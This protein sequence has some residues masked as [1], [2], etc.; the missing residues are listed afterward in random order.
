[1]RKIKKYSRYVV[2]GICVLALGLLCEVGMLLWQGIKDDIVPSDVGIVLGSSITSAGEPSPRLRA[3]LDRAGELW[4]ARVFP[5]IIVS[6]GVEPEGRDEAAVMAR[7]LEQHWHVPP[8]AIL[9]DATGNT[10]HDTA[11]HS[12]TLMRQYGYHSALVIS[13]YFHIARSQD[14]LEWAGINEVHH[15]HAHYF[16]SRDFYSLAREM[17]A[18]PIYRWYHAGPCNI[19]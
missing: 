15:A 4:Q 1:M 12:A 11:C 17:V 19:K 13:Q 5:V 14:A 8:S 3:R 18:W 10:T 16:E 6:G 2:G 7:Y 9:R